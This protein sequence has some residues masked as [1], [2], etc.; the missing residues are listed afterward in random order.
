MSEASL[1]E[2]PISKQVR[3]GFVAEEEKN[4]ASACKLTFSHTLHA[5]GT[6]SLLWAL[7]ALTTAVE[8]TKEKVA[9]VCVC[10]SVRKCKQTRTKF[11]PTK[12]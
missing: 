10:V 3:V 11:R 12:E 1:L 9:E 7:Q 8:W 2:K 6:Q 5:N 4:Q